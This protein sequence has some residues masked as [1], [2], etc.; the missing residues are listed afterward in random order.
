MSDN[1]FLS[2]ALT[3]TI[4]TRRSFL[5]W[6][7]VLGGTAALAGGV[8]VGLKAAEAATQA[9]SEGEWITAACWHNC[10]GQRCLLKAQVVD[11]VVQRV[12]TDDTHPD[13]ADY[14]QLRACA[15]GRSQQQQVFGS[16][17]LK[18]PMKRKNWEPGGG[19]KELRGRDEWVR[20]SWDE[21]LDIY[22]S[23]LQR[24]KDKYG[25]ESI[26][27]LG[28]TMGR[29]LTLFGGAVGTW[30]TTSWGTWYYTGPMIGLGDGLNATS[31]ND[32]LDMRNSNLIVIWG[33]NPAWSSQGNSMK[34]YFDAKQAGAK[35]LF[36]DPY[37]NDTAMILADEWVPVRP[38]TDHALA[39]GMAH[40]LIVED[41][42]VANPLIDWDFLNRCTVGFDKDH[43]PEGTDPKENF[44][45]YVLG[46][47]DG[48]PKTPEWAAD[49]CGVTPGKIRAIARE[50]AQTPRVALLTAWSAA[51]T[52]NTDSWP[53][54]FMTLGAMTGNIGQPGR[55]T[56]VS[57]WERTANG[58]PF[59]IGSGSGG[60]PRIETEVKPIS[61]KINNNELWDA[62]LNGQYIAGYQDVKPIDIQMIIH[63][64]GSALNQKV[65]MTKGIAAH[66]KVEF[67][68]TQNFVLNTNAKYSDLVLPVTTQWERAG[69]FKGN[70]EHLIW[71]RNVTAP[72]FEA[73]HDE[74]IA[75]E[76]GKRLGFD[77]AIIAPLS[78]EQQVFNQLAGA[79]V[80]KPDGSGREPLVTITADDIAA[81][82]VT[83][84][85]QTG[86]I[87]LAEFKAKGI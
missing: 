12:K 9:A 40:T 47:Y 66:R 60:V 86:R 46:T 64:G 34:F 43:L 29:T 57:C 61:T 51:R 41:D 73:K 18:Y 56:G 49:I 48:Q 70:R 53:Q 21:A 42:P 44:K 33:G 87:T 50:I 11:G 24:I 79:S 17:R 23:E 27:A 13:T 76:V 8:T 16:D 15:R 22:A 38:G 32:R 71:A 14:P 28:G 68:V 39:L 54:V 65:G 5:K 45:D 67:V 69:Y 74:W 52:N 36:L 25:N 1:E 72:L 58:G 84:E 59:L 78:P 82:G 83:G 26:L 31:N 63:D 77:P 3:D 30:G 81:M 20:I 7:G 55:M 6:S 19:N 85:P 4:L 35:F 10:G 2:K 80:I 75:A 37:Y 62:I